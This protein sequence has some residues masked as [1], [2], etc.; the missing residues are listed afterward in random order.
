[1]NADELLFALS[2]VEEDHQL[3]LDKIQ[4][5]KEAV[6]Y[7]VDPVA[8]DPL[9]VLGQ[10]WGAHRYFG[11]HFESHLEQEEEGLFPLL[12]RQPGGAEVVARLRQEHAVIRRRREAFG[13]CLHVAAE[14]GD[15]IPPAV[16][17]D[18]LAYGW[19]LWEL[20][21]RHAHAETVAVQQCLRRL[22]PEMAAAAPVRCR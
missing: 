12:E 19:E 15:G 5:L 2:V 16:V 17:R 21:D 9:L 11:S 3:V 8:A 18:L 22:A 6:S 13:N 1:M 14:L 10:L 7:A 4:G 20:L